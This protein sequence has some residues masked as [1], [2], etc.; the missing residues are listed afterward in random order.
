MMISPSSRLAGGRCTLASALL[1]TTVL[2]GNS[3]A[4]EARPT[5]QKHDATPATVVA[6]PGQ[7]A[8]EKHGRLISL[9]VLLPAPRQ[10]DEGALGSM[11]SKAVGIAYDKDTVD[12]SFLVAKAPFYKVELKSGTYVINNIGKPYFENT[13]KLAKEIDDAGMRK[14]VTDNQAWISVDW[15]G[16]EEPADLQA[17]YGDIGKIA[18]ALAR[19]D[20]LAI[21]SPEVGQLSPFNDSVA[22][23][24]ASKDPLGIFDVDSDETVSISDDDPK[25]LAAQAQARKAWPEFARAFQA[26]AGR[27]FAVSGRIV[28]GKNSETMWLAVTS[29]D[30]TSVHG[31]LDNAPRSLT[32]LKMGQD[33]HVKVS[34]ID[35]W[36]YIGTNEVP[37]GGFTKDALEHARDSAKHAAR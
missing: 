6:E 24:M 8:A 35:D 37:V 3:S 5:S 23:T 14:A 21:Y 13:E 1:L 20:A 4:E 17:V 32:T 11:V 26:K 16:K 30:A 34:E 33:L 19:P 29:I 18:A 2:A 15:A 9:V 22:T 31:T 27:N 10:L 28:E 12:K 7:P 25:L 36:L